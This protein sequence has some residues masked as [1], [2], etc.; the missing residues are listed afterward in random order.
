MGAN[1]LCSTEKLAVSPL[2]AR[3]LV[4]LERAMASTTP[5]PDEERPGR[6]TTLS[7][8]GGTDKRLDWA[9]VEVCMG[10]DYCGNIKTHVRSKNNVYAEYLSSREKMCSV[11]NLLVGSLRSIFPMRTGRCSISL[12]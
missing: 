10:S 11:V 3:S 1:W 6:D 5:L 9:G 4:V 7:A 12:I 8:C 2:P